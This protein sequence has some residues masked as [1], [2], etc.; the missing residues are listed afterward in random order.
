M[1]FRVRQR[2]ES[3]RAF[4]IRATIVHLAC[5]GVLFVP[6]TPELLIAAALGFFIRVFSWEI[7]S[8]RYFSHRSFKTSRA[9]QFVLA[10]LAAA[11]GQR[12]VLWW[13]EHHRRHHKH[14]DR[15]PDD[16]H[17]PV[18]HSLWQAHFGWLLSQ[19]ALDTDLDSVRDLTRFPELVWINKY[20]YFF[21]LGLLILTF[22][23][24]HH[25]TL[26][27][28]SG[29]GLAAVVWVFFVSMVLSQ[30]SAFSL[31][32]AMHGVKRGWFNSRRF[33][34]PDSTTNMWLLA[35][36]TLGGA[37]HNNHHRY[38][39]SARAGFYWYELDLAYLLLRM[40][41]LLRIVWDLHPV[42]D[43]VL[44]EGRRA[45]GAAG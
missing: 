21:P 45:A 7:G 38:M 29:L 9:F 26:F 3:L 37:W 31:N 28:R 10:V 23:V 4:K 8:H 19:D 11:S 17:S 44:A 43:E 1:E 18:L 2:A 35:I 30:Q 39:N 5:F 13:A 24:G 12:G 22:I 33:A 34:T 15:H 16:L 32:T 41:A 42:P 25:T 27:G 6:F 14:S 20:H 40:L 36:P